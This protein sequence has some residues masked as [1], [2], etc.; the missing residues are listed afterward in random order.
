MN[1][2]AIW[3]ANMTTAALRSSKFMALMF[4]Y[5]ITSLTFVRVSL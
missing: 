4:K 1:E 5:S 3:I 2:K